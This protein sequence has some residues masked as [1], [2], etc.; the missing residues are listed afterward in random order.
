MVDVV[1]VVCCNRPLTHPFL[2]SSIHRQFDSLLQS[3][4]TLLNI[5][6]KLSK[7]RI[8]ACDDDDDALPGHAVVPEAP[9]A[10]LPN[11]VSSPVARRVSPLKP[12]ESDR[13]LAPFEKV[14]DLMK[15]NVNL[16]IAEMMEYRLTVSMVKNA[17][18]SP[19]HRSRLKLVLARLVR[20]T[21]EDQRKFL[22]VR[23]VPPSG[24]ANMEVQNFFSRRVRLL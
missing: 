15:V 3:Q 5:A 14:T 23:E 11:V 7:L 8:L 2:L 18:D 21:P 13:D 12:S 24:L 1:V 10:P 22:N 17:M 6:R 16:A 4:T 9:P 19:K 20:Y